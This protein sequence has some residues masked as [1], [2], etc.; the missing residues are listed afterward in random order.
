MKKRDVIQSGAA[1]L[2][3]VGVT[4]VLFNAVVADGAKKDDVSQTSAVGFKLDTVQLHVI[5]VKSDSAVSGPSAP[6]PPTVKAILDYSGVYD[7][8]NP[9]VMHVDTASVPGMVVSVKDLEGAEL[10]SKVLISDLGPTKPNTKQLSVA[11]SDPS[12]VPDKSSGHGKKA[13]LEIS[14]PENKAILADKYVLRLAKEDPAAGDSLLQHEL[15]VTNASSVDW[16]TKAGKARL[17]IFKDNKCI[18][19]AANVFTFLAAGMNRVI[20]ETMAVEV[21]YTTR[22]IDLNTLID[23][24]GGPIAARIM[25]LPRYVKLT[26][27][28]HASQKT[29]AVIPANTSI[30]IR[31][32]SP[33]DIDELSSTVTLKSPLVYPLGPPSETKTLSTTNHFVPVGIDNT[34]NVQNVKP[35]VLTPWLPL[36]FT[37]NKLDYLNAETW[38]FLVNASEGTRVSFFDSRPGYV[39]CFADGMT[40]KTS[41][42]NAQ[43]QLESNTLLSVSTVLQ[44]LTD[45]DDPKEW[46]TAL[47]GV[48][49]TV[50]TSITCQDPKPEVLCQ[51]FQLVPGSGTASQKL[52]TL[53]KNLNS[54]SL[55]RYEK[56]TDKIKLW[57]S[58]QKDED[59]AEQQVI[60]NGLSGRDFDE[61]L[62]TWK[63]RHKCYQDNIEKAQFQLFDV[64]A[65]LMKDIAKV[66]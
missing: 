36:T 52:T 15:H 28:Q 10:E 53:S 61:S 2:G 11:L 22:F 25:G 40:N 24:N 18:Y 51:F 33:L 5:T 57:K 21:D 43:I 1:V 38:E 63:A 54:V 48:S 13:R 62:K 56:I 42:E 32:A 23:S 4:V 58:Q 44:T 60:L 46:A 9:Y 55:G 39:A 35:P 20:S 12:S 49:A 65:C 7:F 30:E 50:N 37:A 3:I 45:H 29:K 66:K 14:L 6:A 59:K 47:I 19:D 31:T 41:N 64:L 17:T 8:T 16:E 27:Y 26:P 34:F